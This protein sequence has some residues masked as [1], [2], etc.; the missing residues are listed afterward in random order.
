ME[1]NHVPGLQLG[2]LLFFTIVY[3]IVVS[4]AQV[5]MVIKKKK[6]AFFL[7]YLG[8]SSVVLQKQIKDL[9]QEQKVLRDT[10]WVFVC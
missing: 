1:L 3:S 6:S 5:E 2:L 8:V 10:G 7:S 9:H 4:S